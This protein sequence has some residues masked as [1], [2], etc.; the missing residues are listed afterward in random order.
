VVD[1]GQA[2]VWPRGC[3]NKQ[4]ARKVDEERDSVAVGKWIVGKE[5]ESS[6][7]G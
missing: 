4:W 2:Y 1:F 6:L 3:T 7:S 5:F